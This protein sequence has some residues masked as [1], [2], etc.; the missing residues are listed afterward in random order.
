MK[1]FLKGFTSPRAK[2]AVLGIFRGVLCLP[3]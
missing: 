1:P 3:T 2:P